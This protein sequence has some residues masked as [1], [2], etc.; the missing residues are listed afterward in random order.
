MQLL[1]AQNLLARWSPRTHQRFSR[2]A[3]VALLAAALALTCC[4]LSDSEALRDSVGLGSLALTPLWLAWTWRV[5]NRPTYVLEIEHVDL[6][7]SPYGSTPASRDYYAK[8]RVSFAA[9]GS[10]RCAREVSDLS[11]FP[12]TV[13][14]DAHAYGALLGEFSCALVLDH[15]LRPLGFEL[16]D[17]RQSRL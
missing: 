9:E 13:Q 17:G 3:L 10:G 7:T 5:A 1:E 6:E 15:A 12:S 16:A 14:I 2:P 11:R 4:G 8:F